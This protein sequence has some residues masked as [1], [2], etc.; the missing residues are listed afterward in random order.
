MPQSIGEPQNPPRCCSCRS[1]L[2]PQLITASPAA[3]PMAERITSN[4]CTGAGLPH[5]INPSQAPSALMLFICL[6]ISL[7]S[8]S[9]GCN[10]PG[11]PDRILVSTREGPH[12]FPPEVMPT[13]LAHAYTRC[14]Q[15]P[16]ADYYV[17]DM[18]GSARRR[19]RFRAQ[20]IKAAFIEARAGID[21]VQ[22]FRGKMFALLH[23][24]LWL[25]AAL[26]AF[27]PRIVG[28]RAA[29]VGSGSPA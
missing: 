15:I 17:D 16:V 19:Q 26:I 8:S 22:R 14:G 2:L 4:P 9:P 7:A 11:L 3:N 5:R 13:E 18:H 28:A 6:S 24:S 25:T 27:Q 12:E 1:R 23:K 21:I 10:G 20:Q 29:V